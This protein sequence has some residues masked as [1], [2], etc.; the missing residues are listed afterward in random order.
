MTN[1]SPQAR[2]ALIE[3]KLTLWRNT[4]FDAE[5]DAKVAKVL[6]NADSEAAAAQRLKD[7]LKAIATLEEMLTVTE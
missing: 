2:Q 5:L 1:I 3:Q 7:C 6:G 4:A